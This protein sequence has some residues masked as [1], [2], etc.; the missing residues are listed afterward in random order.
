MS[1][2]EHILRWWNSKMFQDI[3]EITIILQCSLDFQESNGTVR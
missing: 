3:G 1:K 2:D